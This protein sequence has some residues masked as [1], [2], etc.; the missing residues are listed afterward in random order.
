MT[1]AQAYIIEKHL[2]Q[3]YEEFLKK[4]YPRSKTSKEDQA[5]KGKNARPNLLGLENEK[6][7]GSN[8]PEHKIVFIFKRPFFSFG[9]FF[10]F[11]LIYSHKKV[12]KCFAV[13]L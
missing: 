13:V 12:V 9:E 2:Q 4:R 8:E 5:K 3:D 11:K 1:P 7:K 10:F 6:L